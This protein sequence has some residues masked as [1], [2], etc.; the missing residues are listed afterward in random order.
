MPSSEPND[1]A[2]VLALLRNASGGD[3]AALA[4]LFERYRDRLRRIVEYRL[5]ARLRGRCDPSDVI[6]EAW[7]DAARRL[8]DYLARPALPF[9]LWLRL[10]VKQKVIDIHRHELAEKRGAG[11]EL[12]AFAGDG[13]ESSAG[14][15]ANAFVASRSSASGAAMREETRRAIAVALEELDEVDREIILL[16]YFEELSNSEAARV[17]EIE[18]NTA[19]QRHLRALK[20][21]A[22]LLAKKPELRS[23]V[24]FG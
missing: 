13:T 22:R 16:R 8:Q 15:L 9:F 14:A 5:D 21:L 12:H 20:N 3:A 7:L 6:Q 24:S 2:E 11:R 4:M 1:S 19:S 23:H 10:L 18:A 17:L